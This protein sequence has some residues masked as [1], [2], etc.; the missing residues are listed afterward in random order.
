MSEYWIDDDGCIAYGTGDNY[1][2]VAEI[3]V[4]KHVEPL[5]KIIES[6]IIVEVQGGVAYCDDPRIE[7]IDHDNQE[8]ENG[9]L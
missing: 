8:D 5:T 3:L 4:P 1:I 2:T 6:K 7:I 9:Q